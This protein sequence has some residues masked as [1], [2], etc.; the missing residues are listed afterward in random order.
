[1]QPYQLPT[2]SS[3]VLDRAIFRLTGAEAQHYLNGQCSQDVNLA[4][5]DTAVYAV[6]TNFKGKMDGDCY[7]RR[8]KED[9]LIDAPAELRE[10]LFMRL[11]RYI[12]ADDA[13]LTD[14]TNT[15]DIVHH[16]S[17]KGTW[18]VNRFGQ[19]GSDT[20]ET[21]GAT[22]GTLAPA[23]VEMARI[24]HAIPAWAAEL[25][26]DTL[27]PEAGLE[28]RAISYTK[29][30][31][32]GQEVISRMRSAG[33]TNRH[34]VLLSLTK[35]LPVGSPLLS[36]GATKEKPAGIITSTCEIDG[37]QIALAYRKRKY[38]DITTFSVGNTTAVVL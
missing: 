7:L 36:K 4:T 31:Y 30:C 16:I 15:F 34:L 18:A 10:D 11:D 20:L 32:T 35:E 37:K 5:T 17:D 9:I 27:P 26:H 25:D 1:M 2:E 12:I 28:E 38:Q 8:H 19:N 13:E 24:S 22:K 6:V 33:K 3:I 29:G 21:K 23:E 14:V